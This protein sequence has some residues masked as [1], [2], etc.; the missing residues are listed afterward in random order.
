MKTYS[1]LKREKV[2]DWNKFL[3]NPPKCPSIE[4]HHACNLAREWVSCA[5]GNQ[6]DIIPRSETGRPYDRELESL[7]I[8]FHDS[9]KGGEWQKAKETLAK[10]EK[11]SEEI[12]AKLL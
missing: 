1:E 5:C 9:I 12:I 8:H 6:C 7:G 4:Y 11:R 2:F 3:E 10:I